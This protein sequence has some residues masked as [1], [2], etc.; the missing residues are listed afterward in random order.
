MSRNY[1]FKPTPIFLRFK[2][3]NN[4]PLKLMT[5]EGKYRTSCLTLPESLSHL[6]VLVSFQSNHSCLVPASSS[7]LL[8]SGWHY[9]ACQSTLITELC[10]NH[11]YVG[12]VLF[13]VVNM[14]VPPEF[15]SMIPLFQEPRSP[16]VSPWWRPAKKKVEIIKHCNFYATDL[17]CTCQNNFVLQIKLQ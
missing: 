4:R 8:S 6:R 2:W 15:F 3:V 16:V 17:I 9:P 14:S 11:F 1:T 12:N 13:F 7:I 5:R 10:L